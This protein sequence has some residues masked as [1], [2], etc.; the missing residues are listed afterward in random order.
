MSRGA[1][2]EAVSA[3][4]IIPET[5]QDADCK[6]RNTVGGRDLGKKKHLAVSDSSFLYC[7]LSST[8]SS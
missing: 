6:P 7:A 2:P 4:T 3:K 8:A 5:K 1:T